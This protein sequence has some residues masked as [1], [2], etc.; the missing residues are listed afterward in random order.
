[1]MII[2]IIIMSTS[3]HNSKITN[4][5]TWINIIH[6]FKKSDTI[7][8]ES[9]TNKNKM[10]PISHLRTLQTFFF[11]KREATFVNYLLE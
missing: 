5:I 6:M 7:C 4:T 11:C 3:I 10:Y 9:I 8:I 1:M 2:M